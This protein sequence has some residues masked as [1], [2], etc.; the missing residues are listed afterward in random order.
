M[1]KI[2]RRRRSKS[3]VLHPPKFIYCSTKMPSCSQPVHKS[4]DS[5]SESGAGLNMPILKELSKNERSRHPFCGAD[6]KQTGAEHSGTL[7]I[8]ISKNRP[9]NCP[10]VISLPIAIL[11]ATDFPDFQVVSE[12]HK[13]NLCTCE[14]KICQCKRWQDMKVYMFSGLQNSSQSAPERRAHVQDNVQ[15]FPLRTP[16]SSLKSC[17]EQAR[18][19][20]DDVTIEDLSGYME[21]FLH[22]PKEMSDM[23][24]MMYT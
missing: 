23:A 17:S 7:T 18:S 13:G 21:Y 3:P 4:S 20:V 12:K 6:Q 8:E 9:G 15:S 16:S 10:A 14:E 5:T 2:Q 19:S 1:I 11:K 24:E 22:I